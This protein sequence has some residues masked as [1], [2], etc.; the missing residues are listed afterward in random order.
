MACFVAESPRRNFAY[1]ARTRQGAFVASTFLLFIGEFMRL[2][3][4]GLGNMGGAMLKGAVASGVVND[5]SLFTYDPYPQAGQGLP[6]QRQ[7]S[8]T[9]AAKSSDVWLL[10]MKPDGVIPMLR[11][12]LSDAALTADLK[13]T[14]RIVLSVA[15]G[16]DL[17]Q[18]KALTPDG[19][20]PLWVRCM[21][22]LAASQR[23]GITGWMASRPVTDEERTTIETVLGANG[24][25]L[26]LTNEEWFHAFTGAV[27]SG[28]AYLFLAAEAIADGAVAEGLPRPLAQQAATAAIYGAGVVLRSSDESPAVW[29]D[30]VCSPGGTTIEGVT[31]L[32]EHGVRRGF[33]AAVRAAA[34]KSRAMAKSR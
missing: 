34:R 24:T 28:I 31:T 1:E 11:E 17:A 13:K 29:K 6:G 7:D 20:G 2:G 25:T 22:N 4:F 3:V 21:P 5:T 12:L 33:I 18:F 14:P 8:A 16:L 32:E 9:E 27:G 10:A 15:A 26:E 19:D 23:A 30:R